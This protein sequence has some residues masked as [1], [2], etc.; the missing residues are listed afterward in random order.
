MEQYR[1]KSIMPGAAI[2]RI[3]FYSTAAQ[4]IRQY[5]VEDPAKEWQR[6][7]YARDVAAAELRQLSESAGVKAGS[8]NADIFAVH[9][10]ML[11]DG[12]YNRA[13]REMIVEK[14]F[15]AEY[16]VSTIGKE[17]AR[18]FASMEDEYFSERAADVRDVSGR[19]LSV[20]ANRQEVHSVCG[21]PSIIVARELTPSETIRMDTAKVLGLVTKLGGRCSHTAILAQSMGLPALTDVEVREE[22]DG[23]MA[24]LDGYR[25]I[26]Y[27]E[28]SRDVVEAV[29]KRREEEAEKQNRLRV[30]TKQEAV[31]RDGRRI[32]LCANAGN[33]SDISAAAANGAEGIGLLRSEFL[34]LGR[35]TYPTEE[36][37]FETYR[38]AAQLMK[39]KRVVIR[40][41]DIGA[42][43]QADYFGL[44]REENPAMGF[45]AIRICLE[46][47]EVFRTQLRAILRAGCYGKAA[48]MYPMITS[49]EEVHRIKELVQE[50]KRELEREGLPYG[51]IEQGIMIETPAAAIISD[52]LAKEVDFFSIGTNDLSQYT[53]AIDRQN[54]RL[55]AFY[56]PHHPAIL[57]M[58]RMTV[59]NGHKE[60]CRVGICGELGAD[61][62]L[63]EEF[64]DMGV[65]EL[66]VSVGKLL[67][68]KNAV[69]KI[70]TPKMHLDK[71]RDGY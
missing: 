23:K 46:R 21:E 25:G 36:E 8:D 4:E 37:L 65:D 58:I 30:L 60:G 31:T 34:Y 63:T 64:I 10:M 11:L 67:E 40:T 29:K 47:T 19:V 52:L 70:K 26:L 56:L 59:E 42:D 7:E 69:R 18:K 32:H 13:I 49:V 54:A 3:R 61:L 55:E 12:E 6:Y 16:A 33:L 38:Q 15:N 2:G 53:L 48:V 44:E 22:W 20:L 35:R 1:G 14:G 9:E 27:L 39:G 50:V 51:E 57:R 17:F 43:K 45:R 71:K 41:L 5:Q 62:S 68:V 28:P 66:S 24:V